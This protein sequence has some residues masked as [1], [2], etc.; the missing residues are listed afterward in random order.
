KCSGSVHICQMTSTGASRRRS[1]TSASRET[2]LSVIVSVCPWLRSNLREVVVH[3]VE[4]GFPDDPVPLGPCRDLLEW[5]GVEGA[6][7]VLGP[8]TPEDQ[9]GTFQHLDVLRDGR[10]RQLERLGE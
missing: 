4:P 6:R 1:I 2:L 9:T 10:Q 8:L 3:P 5:S 7:S